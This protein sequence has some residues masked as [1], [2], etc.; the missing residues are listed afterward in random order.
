MNFRLHNI[1]YY[2]PNIL[3]DFFS[4]TSFWGR[5][6]FFQSVGNWF[7]NFIFFFRASLR[8]IRLQSRT[9]IR[10]LPRTVVWTTYG[11]PW[12]TRPWPTPFSPRSP[13][14][15]WS[16]RPPWPCPSTRTGATWKSS[17][18]RIISFNVFW[19][20]LWFFLQAIVLA[21][22]LWLFNSTKAMYLSI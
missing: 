17:W 11:S 4:W 12:P 22:N 14:P 13:W 19:E 1:D 5:L 3:N 2:V 6:W 7:W 20:R 9:I 15:T 16:P 18:F 21:I 8:T 10:R